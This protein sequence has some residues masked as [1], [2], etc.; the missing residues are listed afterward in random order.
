[1]SQEFPLRQS[2]VASYLH[3]PRAAR[4]EYLEGRRVPTYPRMAIG[5]AGHKG[6][7]VY[8]KTI[9]AGRPAPSIAEI[10]QA[11][12]D[13]IE[14][15]RASIDFSQAKSPDEEKSLVG[16]RAAAFARAYV[17]NVAPTLDTITASE[18]TFS[19]S[20]QVP[21]DFGP[22]AVYEMTGTIDLETETTVRDLKTTTRALPAQPK[23]IVQ[24]ATYALA[25][26]N[27]EAYLP[28][29]SGV[30]ESLVMSET[31]R[32][33]RT[34]RHLP[35]IIPAEALAAEAEIAKQTI[36]RVAQGTERGDYPRNPTA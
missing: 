34:V 24:L 16:D 1:M 14:R 30:I 31:K 21:K 2:S 13:D 17:V 15:Q 26:T 36:V 32:D 28:P 23:H 9:L 20:I 33:G 4:F 11:A 8:N 12:R 3:C 27:A 22:D 10:E 18:R 7:D 25:N 19:L 6:A 5:T 29:P 35:T